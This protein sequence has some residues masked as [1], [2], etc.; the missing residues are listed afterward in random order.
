MNLRSAS[1]LVALSLPSVGIAQ[2]ADV[3][4]SMPPA[5]ELIVDSWLVPDLP[6]VL[7]TPDTQ[8]V[9]VWSGPDGRLLALVN[10]SPTAASTPSWSSP[11]ASGIAA[12][13][14]IIDVSN[15]FSGGA[16]WQG[17]Q[18]FHIDAL[19]SQQSWSQ[20]PCVSSGTD[21]L[22]SAETTSPSAGW[23]QGVLGLGWTSDGGG[24]DLSYGLSWLRSSESPA[25]WNANQ[26]F[27]YG[28][29]LSALLRAES[30]PYQLDSMNGLVAN[31]RVQIGQGALLDLGAS[32]GRSRLVPFGGAP[33]NLSL[34]GLDLQ[35]TSLSLAISSGNLR[36]S[37]IGR[38]AVSPDPLLTGKRWTTFDIGLSWRTPWQGELIL[39]TQ[40]Q[41]TPVIDPNGRDPDA[42]QNRVPYVQY[43]QDL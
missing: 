30:G 42:A 41:L 10:L 7:M 12:D 18:G 3:P 14:R 5:G 24:L 33:S 11:A 23:T 32:L 36:G 39:G 4:V 20:S 2:S 22:L 43:R 6:S 8:V 17:N 25:L 27:T 26:P 28:S 29:G 38:T 31:A 40:S 21:C 16:R 9:P 13:W 19:L 1:L 37:I 35:E 15:L 34:P